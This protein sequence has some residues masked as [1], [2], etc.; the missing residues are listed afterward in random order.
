M[1]RG[2]QWRGGTTETNSSQTE[3]ERHCC[4]LRP[5]AARH[6]DTCLSMWQALQ[7]KALCATMSALR[8]VHQLG[9]SCVQ[10]CLL[11]NM[12]S[13]SEVVQ[14]PWRRLAS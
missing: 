2:A 12:L 14:V 7:D 3:L 1:W 4:M 13:A 6:E 8:T 10:L 5:C 9:R 11:Y